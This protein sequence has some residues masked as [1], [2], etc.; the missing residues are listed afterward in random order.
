MADE[1]IRVEGLS[2]A[3]RALS[4][5]GLEVDDLKDAFAK[6]AQE[7][8]DAAARHA[9]KKS[10]KLA[11]SIRGNRAKS[12]AVVTAGR[13]RVPYAGVQNYGWPRRNIAPAGFMQKADE[14]MQPKS[15]RILEAEL[16]AA[17]RRRGL[18]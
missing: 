18:A 8:A 12:K 6:V 2:R 9:P 7:A 13:A 17:I 4:A 1:G 11:G 3:V 16:N 5:M 10:G 14:E 15:L